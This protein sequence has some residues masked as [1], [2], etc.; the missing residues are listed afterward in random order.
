MAEQLG[1]GEI[2]KNFLGIGDDDKKP[3]GAPTS[4][5]RP[6]ARP[7]GLMASPRPRA[8][9]EDDDDD[10]DK[11][12]TNPVAATT[13]A[14]TMMNDYDD[15]EDEDVGVELD[16]AGLQELLIN[17]NS[18]Y[19][20]HSTTIRRLS[21]FGN[22]VPKVMKQRLA[23]PVV[24]DLLTDVTAMIAQEKL[25][26][27]PTEPETF[28]DPI[29]EEPV[30]LNNKQIQ[31]KLVDAGYNI[32]VDGVVGPQTKKA[33]KAFQKEKGLKVDGIVGKNTTAALAGVPQITSEDLGKAIIPEQKTQME[34]LSERYGLMSPAITDK[35]VDVVEAG[36][37]SGIKNSFRDLF[38]YY[39]SA[40]GQA[41]TLI[42]AAPLAEKVLPINAAKFAEFLGNDGQ[43]TLTSADLSKKDYNHLRKK[44]MEVIERGDDKFTYNDWGFEEKSVLVQDLTKVAWGSLRDPDFRMATLIGQTADGNVRVENG[45]VLVE[46][47]Y[48]FNTG[49]LGRKLQKAFELKD[50]GDIKGYQELSSEALKNRGHLEQLRI[51]AAALGVPQGEGTRFIIDLG[52]AN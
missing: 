25:M 23:S 14:I 2:I 44:A 4:S 49:P 34:L 3:S 43:I 42:S 52:E 35:P 48:D 5:I 29:P 11:S 12:T 41:R 40:E 8:R 50:K 30:K 6:K 38:N 37:F 36:F 39:A 9:P 19:D 22:E 51:W 20:R 21:K 13:N 17:P 27:Q 1:L 10:D 47:V 15:S 31:Q 24:N 16:S 18:L 45:R 33:I 32:T 26:T 46:D 7:E 28:V